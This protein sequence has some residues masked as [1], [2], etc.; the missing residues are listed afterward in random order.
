MKNITEDTIKL[1]EVVKINNKTK[2]F[3]NN[4]IVG[5]AGIKK[6]SNSVNLIIR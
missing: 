4:I 5:I 1:I 6:E 3:I 2:H